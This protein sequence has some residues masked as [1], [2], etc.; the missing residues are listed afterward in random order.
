VIA[1]AET[2]AAGVA[3][4]VGAAGCGAGVA[5]FFSGR[6]AFFFATA[7]FCGFFTGFATGFATAL[8]GGAFFAGRAAFLD[9]FFAFAMGESRLR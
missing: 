7:A 1:A 6:F 8:R 5:F 4:T 9:A 3:C 2:D